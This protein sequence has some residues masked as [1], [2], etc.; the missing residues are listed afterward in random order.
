MTELKR[1]GGSLTMQDYLNIAKRL[2]GDEAAETFKQQIR[3]AEVHS[4]APIF[5]GDHTTPV[6]ERGLDPGPIMGDP[7]HVISALIK[8]V[9]P[10]APSRCPVCHAVCRRNCLPLRSVLA[11]GLLRIRGA[12]VG[13][14]QDGAGQARGEARS[15]QHVLQG[16]HGRS[17]LAVRAILACAVFS[18][19]AFSF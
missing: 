2:E 12:H 15:P 8:N 6:E 5:A 19:P 9:R 17:R 1:N 11:A 13:E 3:E 10:N 7:E 14:R 18:A 4:K 16:P